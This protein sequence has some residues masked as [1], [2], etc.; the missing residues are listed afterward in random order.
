MVRTVHSMKQEPGLSRTYRCGIKECNREPAFKPV[1]LQSP[2]ARES[3]LWPSPRAWT[4]VITINL[5]SN[6]TTF[7]AEF[8]RGPTKK[9]SVTRYAWEKLLHNMAKHSFSSCNFFSYCLVPKFEATKVI[10][11]DAFDLRKIRFWWN[12]KNTVNMAWS[13]SPTTGD[14]ALTAESSLA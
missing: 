6:S 14:I 5:F 1:L 9:N 7:A 10:C 2:R 13:T 4:S 3:W 11:L 12:I 8:L